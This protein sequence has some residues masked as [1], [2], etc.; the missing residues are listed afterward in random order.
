[1]RQEISWGVGY[2]GAQETARH[3]L[4]WHRRIGNFFF[5]FGES[6]GMTVPLSWDSVRTVVF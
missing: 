4:V 3:I 5:F 2:W 6:W 1:M